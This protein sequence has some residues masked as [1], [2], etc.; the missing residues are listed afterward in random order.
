[1]QTRR[2]AHAPVLAG[3]VEIE[4]LVGADQRQ[5]QEIAD[6]VEATPE[7]PVVDDRQPP[8]TP[9]PTPAPTDV[10]VAHYEAGGLTLG[11]GLHGRRLPLSARV[12][13]SYEFCQ[14][15]AGNVAP[16]T[17]NTAPTLPSGF[18]VSNSV[19]SWG[20][21]DAENEADGEKQVRRYLQHR[22]RLV[23]AA[24]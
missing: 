20:G 16:L 19:R 5:W 23:S 7:G 2:L 3:S 6:L 9:P 17:I 8:G 11:D 10:F 4:T 12:F 18:V 1:D 21:V 13:A 15:S 24:D 14:G 22:D